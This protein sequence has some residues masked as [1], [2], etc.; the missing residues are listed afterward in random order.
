VEATGPEGL[1]LLA[2]HAEAMAETQYWDGVYRQVNGTRVTVQCETRPVIGVSPASH[3]YLSAFLRQQGYIVETVEEGKSY[4]LFLHREKF[5]TEDEKA[6]VEEIER[7][8]APLVR[9]GRWPNGARSALCV[10]GDIDALT[11]WDYY[12]RFAGK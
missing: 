10:T 7:S 1:T 12:L 3:P 4:S 9:M 5:G 6:L 8:A 11:I 2:R